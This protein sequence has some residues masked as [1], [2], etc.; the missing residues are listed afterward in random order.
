MQIEYGEEH[1]I[2]GN[3]SQLGEW[4]V[5]RAPKMRWH[6]G[7]IWSL[8]LDLPVDQTLEFKVIS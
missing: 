2:V 7:D 5:G 4:D 1:R 8:E 3:V 6:D